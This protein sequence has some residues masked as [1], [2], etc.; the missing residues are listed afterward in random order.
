MSSN[1]GMEQ[2]PPVESSIIRKISAELEPTH[3]QV[4]FMNS[5]HKLSEKRKINLLKL[6]LREVKHDF[7]TLGRL[8]LSGLSRSL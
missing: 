8:I 5:F 6:S 3:L 4:K 2:K 1:V 7:V